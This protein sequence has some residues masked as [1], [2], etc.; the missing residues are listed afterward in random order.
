MFQL[1]VGYN[2]LV[3]K[4]YLFSDNPLFKISIFKFIIVTVLNFKPLKH[5]CATE[6]I[7]DLAILKQS[8]KKF[9]KMTLGQVTQRQ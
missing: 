8:C 7:L 3:L 6:L 4:F 2:I 1:F 5:L 9:T